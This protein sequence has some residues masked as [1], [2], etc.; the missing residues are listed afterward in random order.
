MST[1]STKLKKFQDNL[2]RL[3]KILKKVYTFKGNTYTPHLRSNGAN[4]AINK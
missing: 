4:E 3:T 2:S 1:I